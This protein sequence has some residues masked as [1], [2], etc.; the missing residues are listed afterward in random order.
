MG[1][2]KKRTKRTTRRALRRAHT[3]TLKA[4]AQA[5][6]KFQEKAARKAAKDRKQGKV[7][8]AAAEPP[9]PAADLDTKAERKSRKKA[10]DQVSTPRKIKNVLGIV[11]VL[12][13]VLAPLAYKAATAARTQLDTARARKI[14]VGVHQLGEFTGHGAAL[15]ARIAG[16][17]PALDELSDTSSTQGSESATSVASF[18]ESTRA[19]LAE[20]ATAVHAAERMPGARRKAAHSAVAAELDGI[21]AQVLSRLG[22]R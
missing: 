21:D 9:Q 5:E 11:R 19:R 12:S 3:K 22:V 13:P 7:A 4:Q 16:L 10:L 17:E 6:K 15:N 8:P 18:R 1:L 2:F 20:L 14:G